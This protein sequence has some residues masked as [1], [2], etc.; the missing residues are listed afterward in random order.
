MARAAQ[1]E[2]PDATEL[3]Q[4]SVVFDW[5]YHLFSAPE[6]RRLAE[7]IA[8]GAE[9][10]AGRPGMQPFAARAL[11]AIATADD[12]AGSEGA[13]SDMF[14]KQW[15]AGL[16]PALREGRGLERLAD[17]VA[18]LELCHAVRDNLNLDLWRQAAGFFRQFPVAL[19]LEYYPAPWLVNGQA[20]R[21]PAMP[22]AAQLNPAVDGEYARRT[23]L[24]T[25][26]YETNSNE[27]Q[28]LQGWLTHDSFRLV[29]ASG[30][31]YEFLWMNPYQPGLSYYS[32]PLVLH[33]EIGGRLAARSSWD[34]DAAWI[35]YFN[36]ELQLYADQQ[37]S[38]VGVTPPA[39]PVVFPHVAVARVEG[40]ATFR[41]KV[42]E[43]DDLFLVGL[44]AGRTYWLKAGEKRFAPQI[45]GRGGI[46]L[47]KVQPGEETAIEVRTSD[48]NPPPPSLERKR[49]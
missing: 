2:A 6:R 31:L 22:L 20:F 5:C 4:L 15:G 21:Q 11:A 46:L 24:L 37:R 14:E 35:G 17:R 7:R 19:L 30:A 43:G 28:F 3:R 25:V 12:W 47:L 1:P 26:A 9:A 10:L 36:G 39:P 33:D 32:A 16:L 41:V 34:D 40:D 18:F 49:R 38:A 48:P 27:T 44:E 42:P 8:R 45:A 29:S 13:L 23:D